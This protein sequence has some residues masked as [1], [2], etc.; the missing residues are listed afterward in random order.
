MQVPMWNVRLYEKA[1][2]AR[3]VYDGYPTLFTIKLHHGGEFTKFPDVNY[4]DG[5]VTYVDMVDIEEFSVH[6][7]DAIMKGLGYS[8]PPVIYYHFRLP[9]GDM[10]F[11]PRALGN[12]D[13]VRNLAQYVKEHKVIRVYTE[14]GFT[15]LLT[16]FMAPKP[17]KK[18][19]IEQ[20]DEIEEHET[21]TTDNQASDRKR[22][23]TKD[24]SLSLSPVLHNEGAL[25]ISPVLHN[26]GAFSLSP[27]YNRKRSWTKDKSLSS[28]NK[29]LAMGDVSEA[30]VDGDKDHAPND[31]DEAANEFDLGLNQQI[32]ESNSEFDN[33]FNEEKEGD[34]GEEVVNE[35]SANVDMRNYEK[36]ARVEDDVDMG[37]YQMDA[38]VEDEVDMGGY[39]M[40][41]GVEDEVTHNVAEDERSDREDDNGERSDGEDDSDER[42]DGEEDSDDSD[43]WVDEDNIIPEVEVDMKDFYMSV[44]LEA[45]FMEKRVTNP[46][47]NDSG[48][49]PKD[50]EDLDV[51]DNDRWD[52]MDEG[53][54][55]ERKRRVLLKELGKETRCSQ[56]EIH[57]VTFRIGQKYKS[58]KELKEKIQL[59][60]LETRR[61]IF[62]KKNDKTRLR[63]L[64]KGTV[65]FNE[66][67]VGEPTPCPWVIQGS[68]SN[69][70]GSWMI[71]TYNHEHRCLHTRKVRSATAKFIG[72]QI[73][74]QIFRAKS[75]AKKQVQGD[76]R[77]Q[78][79][80]L[81]DY[82]LELQ[83]TNPDTTV[84]LEFESE[85]NSNATS[86]RFKRIYVCMGGMK[87]GFRACLRDFLGFDGAF[88]K[89]PFL[90]QI[91]TAVGVDS[92]NGIYPL[93][94]AIVESENTQ[95][96]KWFLEILGDDLDLYANSNFTFISDRQKGLQAAIAQL[97]PCAEHRYCL[98]HIHDN[99]KRTW[100]SNE[101][102]EH[103]WN[104]A[105]ATTV[106]EF[107]H[108][109]NEFNLFDKDAYNWLKQIPPQHWARSHFTGRAISDMLLNNL[110]EVFN[111]KLVEGRDKP[112]ITCLEYIREYMMKRICNVIKVQ[113]KCVG[114]LTPSATKIMDK[115]V[116]L[117]SQYTTRWNG[118]DKYQVKGPWQDQQ[119]VDMAGRVCSCRK[120]ELT[121]LPC[122]HVIAVLNDKADNGEK[123]G[124]L[125][126]YVHR[127]HWL[128]TWKAAYVYKVEPI[129]GRAMWPISD[130]PIKITP[131]LH[132]NQPGRPKNKRRQSAG[133][134]SQKKGENGNGASGSQTHAASG[135]GKLTR[136]FISV[137]CSKCKNKG[138]NT[139]TCKG[140]VG[141]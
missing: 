49:D 98:R 94:Y 45:E 68:R 9:K 69:K 130:C 125:H 56:G 13:D 78:Y 27:E 48:E 132:H 58:K 70:D 115:N 114:P 72:K 11:G 35:V 89:G 118:S 71:K 110:C 137:T 31:F 128:E 124:E 81:R 134:R 117:A 32:L 60:A 53:S 93:A 85:P 55:M 120:W 112:L 109:M 141:N 5:T 84:K 8:V 47:H 126:T 119:V 24:K 25:S 73:M 129:K 135:S 101:H 42:S 36:D 23:W 64:C 59:H 136:K 52:S 12:D 122:K 79:E 3:L 26:K 14:H 106:Q 50:P 123:I 74:D 2:N 121:G 4:I 103:L 107:N 65:A 66:G 22:S 90:G 99:M 75:N 102:K 86:R 44:D 15:K 92:N 140:Q 54:D 127:V 34:E 1:F 111:S 108:L 138:H 104:C 17:V 100:R 96:W 83:S 18:V 91:L 133:E 38:G 67:D 10:H 33:G 51:I 29:K 113:N 77:K 139:R 41:T 40:D 28:C 88:M 95:S 30:N 46:M 80:V 61:N 82:I 87:K 63:A 19:T 16:Y 6:E 21:T 105:T 20:L 39:Q 97:F 57:K 37:G 131:P 116:Y 43:F 62:F 7:M 76:Y